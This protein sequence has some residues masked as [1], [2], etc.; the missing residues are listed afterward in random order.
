MGIS[1]S[2]L[3]LS[4]PC[5]RLPDRA[6]GRCRGCRRLPAA[7]A[8]PEAPAAP[9]QASQSAAPA[10]APASAASAPRCR[11][12]T[13]GPQLGLDYPGLVATADALNPLDVLVRA[14]CN[15][16]LKESGFILVYASTIA[17]SCSSASALMLSSKRIEIEMM[18]RAMSQSI[19]M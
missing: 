2:S 18:M 8:G 3:L 7:G 1:L 5:P 11:R 13:L 6:G 12:R 10:P 16:D 9:A 4:T 19:H 14:A 15:C 17:L